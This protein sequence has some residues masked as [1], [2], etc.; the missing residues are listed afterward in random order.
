MK[1][2]VGT[3]QFYDY[4]YSSSWC[5]VADEEYFFRCNR[6]YILH[7]SFKL[8]AKACPIKKH[9][10]SLNCH[11]FSELFY[12][13]FREQINLFNINPQFLAYFMSP[14]TREKERMMS[15][16]KERH[17]I[18]PSHA[19]KVRIEHGIA[20][21]YNETGF[22]IAKVNDW[23]KIKMTSVIPM[24]TYPFP[25]KSDIFFSNEVVWK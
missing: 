23:I 20:D 14:K 1:L 6:D 8:I 11:D 17:K 3:Y 18:D 5:D 10:N 4:F 21:V 9:I 19:K 24:C 7:I 25:T 16:S 15:I 12:L 13:L 2:W 22:N